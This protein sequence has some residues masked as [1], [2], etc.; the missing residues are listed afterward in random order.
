M[1]SNKTKLMHSFIKSASQH[2][3]AATATA[4]SRC[5]TATWCATTAGRALTMSLH[6][7]MLQSTERYVCLWI[8][9]YV[10]VSVYE[11]DRVYMCAVLIWHFRVNANDLTCTIAQTKRNEKL[12]LVGWHSINCHDS[13][14]GDRKNCMCLCVCMLSFRLQVTNLWSANNNVANISK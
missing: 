7:C 5:H 12:S 2:N 13:D 11:C 1:T 14:G 3:S 4:T 10:S 6:C 8:Y 9:E